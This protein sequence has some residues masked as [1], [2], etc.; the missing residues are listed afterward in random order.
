LRELVV[1]AD[2]VPAYFND[3]LAQPLIA[4]D[5]EEYWELW[6]GKPYH[7]ASGAMVSDLFLMK[8]QLGNCAYLL[9]K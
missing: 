7:D 6:T 5:F 1:L 2:Y 9:T 4:G 3:K 8:S